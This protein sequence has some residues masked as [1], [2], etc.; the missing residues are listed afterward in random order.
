MKF[1]AALSLLVLLSGLAAQTGQA[2]AGLPTPDMDER[3]LQEKYH[4]ASTEEG[5]IGALQ[6]QESVVRSFAATKLA[7]DGDK[8]AIRPILDALAAETI[9]GVKII[10]A[11]AAARLD[12]P[13]G[14]SALKSMCEDRSWSPGSPTMR[15]V[16]AQ[17]M[18]IVVDRQECL[19][20]ILEVLRSAL[21][22]DDF[23]A[24]VIALNLLPRFKQVSPSQ[25][26]E[27]RDLAAVYLKSGQPAYRMV[28]SQCVRDLGGPWAISQLRAA[29][30]AEREEAIRNV[31]ANSLFSVRQ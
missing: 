14:F 3:T 18:V 6:H 21:A 5:L 30:D 28:A 15:M 31:I 1:H 27:M 12:S 9:P 25:L 24:P 16:A 11:T 26:D 19:S 10:L 13:E 22:P 2:I 8:A 29:L 7:N 17:T 4:I 23:S 20:D